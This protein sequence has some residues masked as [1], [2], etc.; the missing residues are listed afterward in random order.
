MICGQ[1]DGIPKDLFKNYP[2]LKAF[3]SRIA[4]EPG[5]KAFYD[6]NSEGFRAAFKPDA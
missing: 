4:T 2:A 1:L 5:V 3:R 6:K